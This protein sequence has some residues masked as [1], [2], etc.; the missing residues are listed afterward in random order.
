M[1]E[2]EKPQMFNGPLD[3]RE[4]VQTL[5]KIPIE[6][7]SLRIYPLKWHGSI[8]M[9]VELLICGQLPPP[10]PVTTTVAPDVSFELECVDALGV[11]NG[12]MYEQQLQASSLW[13]L[14]AQ[15]QRLLDLLKLSTTQAWRPLANT[16]N[17]FVEF[18]FLEL[19]NVSGFITKGGPDGWVTGY[20]VMFSKRKPTWNT[21]LAS[22]GQP[23]IFEANVD[24][25]SPRTHHFKKPILAQYLKLVPTKWERNINMRIEPLGCFKPYRK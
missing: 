3:S 1:D 8:A 17:E 21:V 20:K 11:D 13:Q 6:A 15:K 22:Q 5:F 7:N 23:R 9:R 18:D 16:P 12:L 25:H 2:T 4:P 14:P 24:E 19:R 10:L